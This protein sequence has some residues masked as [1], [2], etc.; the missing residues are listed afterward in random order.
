MTARQSVS[1]KLDKL[2]RQSGQTGQITLS[3]R[4]VRLGMEAAIHFLLAAVLAGAV[5]LKESAP[6]GAALAAEFEQ[7]ED[8]YGGI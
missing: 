8:I 4:S 7:V 6:F 3:A 5:I 1:T 2:R